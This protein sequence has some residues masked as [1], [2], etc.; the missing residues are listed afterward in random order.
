MGVCEN[1]FIAK[2]MGSCENALLLQKELKRKNL[3]YFIN[4]RIR[5]KLF[6]FRKSHSTT[7]AVMTLVGKRN[8]SLEYGKMVFLDLKK[9]SDT[10]YHKIFLNKL[11]SFGI[12]G[13]LHHWFQ[14][15]LSNI[16]HYATYVSIN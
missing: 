3:T 4:Q 5:G 2:K 16:S 15:Y 13:C 6:G 7:H 11:Q 1:A 9:A 10:V 12:R 8:R 14:N